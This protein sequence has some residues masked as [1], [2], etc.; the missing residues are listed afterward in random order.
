MQKLEVLIEENAFGAVRPMEVVADAPVSALVPAL[1]E[2]LKLPKTDLFGKQLVYMLRQS[3][4][5][6]ILPENGTLL[7]A[8]ITTGMRLALDSYVVDGTIATLVKSV[9]EPPPPD[10]GLYSSQTIADFSNLPSSGER[11]TS[12]DLSPVKRKSRPTRRGFLL[13]SGVVLGVVGSGVGY[14]A[15]QAGAFKTLGNIVQATTQSM[16]Q[17]KATNSAPPAVTAQPTLPT[18]LTSV[19]T[20]TRHQGAVRAITWSPDGA[21]LASGADDTKVFIWNMNGA[22]Q[23]TLAHPAS[24]RALAWSADGKRLVT[25]ANTQVTFFR[26]QDGKVLARPNQRHTGQITGLSWAAHEPMQ[27]V[28]GGMDRRAIVWNTTNYRAQTIFTGHTTALDAVTWSGDGTTVASASQGGVVRVWRAATG[29]EVHGLYLDGQVSLNAIAFA[30]TG[31]ML[32]AG[33]ADGKV[34]LWDGLTCQQQ[35]NGLFGPQCMDV[36]QRLS[37]SKSAVRSLAWSPDGRLLA[38]GTTDGMLS[39]WDSTQNQQPLLTVAVKQI[40][41][42]LSWSPDGKHLAAAVGNAVNI[43]ALM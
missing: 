6:R 42:G 18:K 22:V 12:D 21:L 27:V 29:K 43:W 4:G 30:P 20:F 17:Q 28:S 1:V 7:D 37:V 2:E 38:V 40:V 41:R 16:I 3:L 15:Y 5:G 39:L 13:L 36:P 35:G 10:P 25:G 33:G 23:Q 19:F 14:T 11:H 34:R 8:G 9:E 26:A 32:A 24:V 31:M